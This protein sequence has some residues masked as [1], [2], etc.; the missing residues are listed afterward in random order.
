MSSMTLRCETSPS[1]PSNGAESRPSI[2]LTVAQ[3][4]ALDRLEQL[5]QLPGA[6]SYAGFTVRKRALIVGPSGA[7]KTRVIKTLCERLGLPLFCCPSGSWIIYGASTTPHTIMAFRDFVRN[8]NRGVFFLD[9]LDKAL[10]S[11]AGVRMSVWSQGIFGEII[12]LLDGDQRLQ[13]MGWDEE[14]VERLNGHFTIHAAGA[15]QHLV[16]TIRQRQDK[17]SLGFAQTNGKTESYIE[18]IRT[19]ETVPQELLFRFHPEPV[20]IASPS[21]EDFRTALTEV[22]R[23]LGLADQAVDEPVSRALGSGMGMRWVEGYV[24]DLVLRQ[25]ELQRQQSKPVPAIEK[26]NE[27]LGALPPDGRTEKLAE[28]VV[29]LRVILHRLLSREPIFLK[30][31][32]SYPTLRAY[33][34]GGKA[35]EKSFGYLAGMLTDGLRPLEIRPLYQETVFIMEQLRDVVLEAIDHHS[36]GLE[37]CGM[38]DTLSA[39]AELLDRISQTAHAIHGE[40]SR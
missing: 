32:E 15:W 4:F 20:F 35:D 23:S 34:H 24:T 30:A 33:F 2:S 11:G 14:D 6:Q 37:Q 12:A 13:A 40:E 5:T 1:N 19:D 3:T 26:K 9:E 18:M 25:P 22:H 16:N 36:F 10:P 27:M 31:L 29:E 38:L 21:G 17:A 28:W 39:L 8:H 7:G